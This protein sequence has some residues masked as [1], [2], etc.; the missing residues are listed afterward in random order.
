MNKLKEAILSASYRELREAEQAIL[1]MAKYNSRGVPMLAD[2]MVKWA[3]E[4]NDDSEEGKEGKGKSE[5]R[6]QGPALEG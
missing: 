4:N 5:N 3:L 1:H 2:A 6:A